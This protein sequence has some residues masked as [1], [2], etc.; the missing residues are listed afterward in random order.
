LAQPF[1][2]YLGLAAVVGFALPFVL[3]GSQIPARRRKGSDRGKAQERSRPAQGV[4]EGETAREPTDIPAKG[5]LDILRR[6]YHELEQDRVL[7]VA[8]GVTFYGLLALFPALSAF[9]S[10]YGLTAEPVTVLDHLALV[11]GF[12]PPNAFDLLKEQVTNITSG[13]RTGLG[14]ALLFSLALS[15]WSANAGVKAMFDALNVAYGEDEKRSFI[16]LNLTSLSF[17]LGILLFAIL[18]IGAVAAVP[19]L[20]D[21]LYLGSAAEWLL[22]L[23]RWPLLIAALMLGLAT[24]YRFGPSRNEAQWSWV[25]PGAV[26]ASFTWLIASLLFSWYVANFEDYNKTYGTLG[27]V[28]GLLMWMWISATIVLLGAEINSEAERQTLRDTTT[29]PP[30]PIGSRGADAADNKG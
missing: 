7:A 16:R 12:M 21:Y 14:F 25:S 15:T 9:V 8:A 23:G 20:L 1:I 24:L 6:T 22:W 5:W 19:V 28:I 17:T 2:R 29:G 26:F 30:E 18:S 13:E 3:S 27:A 4:R 10:L 11:Q